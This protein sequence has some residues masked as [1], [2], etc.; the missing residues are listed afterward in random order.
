M[1]R[2]HLETSRLSHS[3]L[4]HITVD[5]ILRSLDGITGLNVAKE[6]MNSLFNA[7]Y[8]MLNKYAISRSPRWSCR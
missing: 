8:Q 3:Q 2:S 6:S 1:V 5:E 7:C 4:V